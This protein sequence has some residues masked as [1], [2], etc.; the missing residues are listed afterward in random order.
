MSEY[1]ER[2]QGGASVRYN[3]ATIPKQDFHNGE[4]LDTYDP[5][6]ESLYEAF[7]I[8]FNYPSMT[9][10]KD[11]ENYSVYM[12]KTYCLLSNEC[13]YIV[14]FIAK[15]DMPTNSQERLINLKWHSL[16]TRTLADQHSLPPH[17]YQPRRLPSLNVVIRREKIDTEAS[18]YICDS[19][20]IIVTLLHT[21]NGSND[22]Q[23]RGTVVSALET[24]Q[25]IITFK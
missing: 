22:Y 3:V 7:D 12:S 8:Y 20:P 11:V 24:Y 15:N 14:V 6:K 18:T 19:L 2:L 1:I 5:D 10:I 13:R 21:K 9:K 16:Q 23:E 25:T 4:L 17:D